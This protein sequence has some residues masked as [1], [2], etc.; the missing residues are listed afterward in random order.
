MKH[1]W[2]IMT[3]ARL[4]FVLLLVFASAL[5]AQAPLGNDA[6]HKVAFENAQM[7][8]L[9][10]D[11]APGQTTTEHRH[12]YDIATISMNDGT[13]TRTQPAGEAWT[14]RP[15][16]AL[17]NVSVTDHTG[18][19]ASHR[20]E[21]TGKRNYQLFAIENRKKSGWSTAAAAS[22]IGM[23]MLQESR[24][25]RSYE[26]QMTASSTQSSHTHTS[27]T[28][29]VLLR[30]KVMSDGPD[31]KAKEYAPAPVG[32]RQLD[33]PGQWILVPPGDRHHL[34]RLGTTD[35]RVVEIEVR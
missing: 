29:I 18:K 16:R 11:I 1:D 2:H 35:A 9:S 22:G 13:E 23:K 34:V 19:P 20:I 25:F 15:P 33:Q 3:A 10:V 8:I 5:A 7:R 6:W 26:I 12:E 32:L 17:G 21:N 27:P 4:S 30:G 31:A 24:A 14:A 28:I